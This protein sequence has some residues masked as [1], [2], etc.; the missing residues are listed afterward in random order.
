MMHLNGASKVVGMVVG[1]MALMVTIFA[2]GVLTRDRLTALEARAAT[3]LR[4][5]NEKVD[6]L[7]GDVVRRIERIED[8]FDGHVKEGAR[9]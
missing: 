9:R 1:F 3:E 5:V 7:K 6:S 2:N 4:A 8:K